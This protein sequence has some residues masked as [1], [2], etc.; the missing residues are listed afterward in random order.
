MSSYVLSSNPDSEEIYWLEKMKKE[1]KRE[2]KERS[3]LIHESLWV[4]A[5]VVRVYVNFV[6][7][8]GLIINKLL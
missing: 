1:T 5:A 8:I 6:V 2:F 4:I 7:Y 3:G